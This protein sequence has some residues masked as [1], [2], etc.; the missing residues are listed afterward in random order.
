MKNTKHSGFTIVEL[1]IVIVV[2]AILAAIT[3]V[4]YNGVQERARFATYRSD[5]ASINKAVL[6]YYAD[7][8][9]YPGGS[10]QNCWTNLSSGTGNFITGLVPTYLSKIPDTPN[11]SGG[12]NYYAY[13]FS[14]NGTEYK[15]IRLV[16]GGQTLPSVE[17]NSD[18]KIDP[19]R[20]ARGWGIWSAGGSAL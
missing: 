11:G 3:I 6:M 14:A 9:S 17:A 2:I 12:Q 15:V 18:V 1:L 16:P 20:A 7:N 4:A 8:G 10:T 13:C 19:S 5:I